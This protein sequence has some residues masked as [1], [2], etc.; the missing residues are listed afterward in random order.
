MDVSYPLTVMLLAAAAQ[1]Q[2]VDVTR[3][4]GIDFRH[5]NFATATKHLVETMGSGAAFLDYDQDGLLDI[6]SIQGAPLQPHPAAGP[7]NRL[8]RNLGNGRFQDITSRAGVG[9]TG[10][11]MGAAVGD[12]DNDGDPDLYVTNFGA[13]LDFQTNTLYRNRGELWFEDA[14][15]RAG[16]SKDAFLLVGFGTRFFDYDNDGD[17]DLLIT[18]CGGAPQLLRNDGGNSS[19]WLTLSLEGQ[20]SNRDG[21]GALI[22]ARLGERTLVRQKTGGGSY[23]SAGD[24]RLHLGLGTAQQVDSL[25]IVW[26]SGKRQVLSDVT[27]NQFLALRED[28]PGTSSSSTR[29]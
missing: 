9:D 20:P 10:Y 14:T 29:R 28:D 7:P 27:A 25:E 6:Y 3:D 1:V 19:G 5:R 2:F 4:A 11:G 15:I 24:G 16:L 21:V 17:L 26:P 8:Y 22:R 12:Y 23:L 13:N 18:N